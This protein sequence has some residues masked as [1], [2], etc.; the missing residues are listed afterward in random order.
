MLHSAWV[1]DKRAALRAG[2]K[3]ATAPMGGAPRGCASCA[4]HEE[5][6]ISCRDRFFSIVARVMAGRSGECSRLQNMLDDAQPR[7]GCR[8]PAPWRAWVGK[9]TLLSWAVDQ[10]SEF[11]VLSTRCNEASR[12]IALSAL[13]EIVVPLQDHLDS[14]TP[15]HRQALQGVLGR[16]QST[17]DSRGLGAALLALLSVLAVESP[18]LLILDDLHWADATSVES[19]LFAVRRLDHEPVLFLAAAHED[20]ELSQAEDMP[21]LPVV[22]LSPLDVAELLDGAVE[23]E[24]ADQLT[25]STG[26]NPLA[27]VEIVNRLSADQRSGRMPL[28]RVVPISQLL[29]EAFSVRTASL[30]AD[31][32]MVI[33]CAAADPR[34]TRTE[35]AQ[36]ADDAQKAVADIESLCDR[37]LLVSTDAEHV[38]FT[39]PLIRSAVYL[40]AL[41][42]TRRQ[43]HRRL[44]AVVSESEVDRRA[45]HL[46]AASV[47][48]DEQTAV[49]LEAAANFALGHGDARVAGDTL[50]R[51]AEFSQRASGTARL[52]AAGAAYCKAGAIVQALEAFD[53]ALAQTTDPLVYADIQLLRAVPE[54]FAT[55]PASLQKRLVELGDQLKSLDADRAA[56]AFGFAALVSLSCSRLDDPRALCGRVL[57]RPLSGESPVRRFISAIATVA[58]AMS[59]DLQSSPAVLLAIADEVAR[60]PMPDDASLPVLVAGTLAWIG[61]W[62]ASSQL[63]ANLIDHAHRSG[64]VAGIPHLLAV[65]SDLCFR[66]GHWAAALADGAKGEELSREISQQTVTCYALIMR[67]RVEAGLGRSA[68]A[69]RRCQEAV[70]LSSTFGC[71]RESVHSAVGFVELT[72]GRFP[73]AIAAF[74]VVRDISESEGLRLI[75]ATPWVA[76]I[77]EAYVHMG[78]IA[79]A[80]SIV[81]DLHDW[82][83]QGDLP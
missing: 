83:I 23:R 49:E 44:A 31:E 81:D 19:L 30:S 36:A 51:A 14:L 52:I 71:L 29:Q 70:E 53:L 79:D 26:G 9:T 41:D 50:M 66:T 1:G 77:V 35:L 25:R 65:R 22:G 56:T 32:L 28:P 75:T 7:A 5:F 4:A 67:A 64:Q 76:D 34:A 12:H 43:A 16:G 82:F 17:A 62:S 73:E 18:V 59:G 69:T 33:L 8:M 37:G 45:W 42:E 20:D 60:G 46:A 63:L 38:V 3:P 2:H 55:G 54:L 6:F 10:A 13:Q 58:E 72:A 21:V 68:E 39:H 40:N 47:G 61:E 27:I 57:D 15:D 48:P 80:R 74:E 24:V 78:K 11:R